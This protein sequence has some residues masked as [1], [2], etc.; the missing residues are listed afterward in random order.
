MTL[1]WLLIPLVLAAY[2]STRYAW[3]RPTINPQLPRILM[4]HMIREPIK[5][6]RFNKM[7]VPPAGFRRQLAWLKSQG[8]TFSFL[9]EILQNPNSEKKRV[10][11]TFDDGYR[12]NLLHAL[13]ILQEFH[14]KATLFPVVKRDPGFDWSSKKKASRTDGELGREEKL[15]DAEIRTLLQS[16]CFELGGHTLTHA[17]L[18]T[19]ND[20]QAWQEIHGCKVALE[21]TFQVP[22]ATFCYPFGLF[23]SRESEMAQKAA[24]L[25]ACTT[26]QGI[27]R[28]QSFALPRIKVAG[29]E[30]LFAFKLRIRTGQRSL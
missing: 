29:G 25:G 19:L 16:G 11:L 10:V 13:P 2:L 30:S 7:R 3:W 24:Y 18:P 28:A 5:G 14:A 15:S 9:S 6:A 17:N 22:V 8:W 21:E 27:D 23:G 4:Y 1:W 20:D 26:E 12:D